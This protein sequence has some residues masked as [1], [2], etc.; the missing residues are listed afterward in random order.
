M[1]VRGQR[2]ENCLPLAHK[3]GTRLLPLASYEPF[4]P[5]LT[6]GKRK[7]RLPAQMTMCMQVGQ[8]PHLAGLKELAAQLRVALVMR[9]GD[10]RCLGGH[11]VVQEDPAGQATP[12]RATLL[13]SAAHTTA[14]V[15]AST[16]HFATCIMLDHHL[17]DAC[18]TR[19]LCYGHSCYAQ[20]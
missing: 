7:N 20:S 11:Q 2:H 10:R 3:D 15:R 8:A 19:G 1:H 13:L 9:G 4:F 12:C 5:A 17:L 14:H 6:K 18:T 16:L